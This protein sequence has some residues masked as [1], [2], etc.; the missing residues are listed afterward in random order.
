M[1]NFG[2]EFN[3]GLMKAGLKKS[4]FKECIEWAFGEAPTTKTR[5]KDLLDKWEQL[6]SDIFSL[7]PVDEIMESARRIGKAFLFL[8]ND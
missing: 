1:A 7:L 8:R 3:T 6:H 5:I 4:Q 2:I